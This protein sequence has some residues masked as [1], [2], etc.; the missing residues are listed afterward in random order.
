[1]ASSGP[2]RQPGGLVASANADALIVRAGMS[3]FQPRAVHLHRSVLH[4]EPG[5]KVPRN[6]RLED[7]SGEVITPRRYQPSGEMD[8]RR[9]EGRSKIKRIIPTRPPGY[10]K[11]DR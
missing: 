2:A 3:A 10:R 5:L 7:E 6:F 4:L 9:G 11:K 8:E 1:M